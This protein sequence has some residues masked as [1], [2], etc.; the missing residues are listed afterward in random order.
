MSKLLPAL[1]LISFALISA[2]ASHKVAN[3]EELQSKALADAASID[4][5]PEEMISRASQ[6][7]NNAE[8]DLRFYSPLH[9]QKA[10]EQLEEARKLQQSAKPENKT[11]A[12]AAAI[13]AEKLVKQAEENREQVKQQLAPA[14][15]HRDI[16]LELGAADLLPREFNSAMSDLKDLI[17]LVESGQLDAVAKQQPALLEEFARVEASTLKVKWLSRAK[18]KLE[19]AED[20]DAEKFAPKSFEQARLAIERAD[21]YTNTNY[22]DR[23]GVKAK[24]DDAFVLASKAL[25]MTMEVQ[26]VFEKK[27]SEIESYM[28]DVQSWMQHINQEAAVQ[29]LEAFTFYEQS[30]LITSRLS[31]SHSEKSASVSVPIEKD[32]SE[33]KSPENY[34]EPVLF[35]K[36]IEVDNNSRD[37]PMELDTMSQEEE[38]EAQPEEPI[39]RAEP[40]ML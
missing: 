32:I 19:E 21:S 20:A 36:P 5:S 4:L 23:E 33:E 17:I 24:A 2:C 37:E 6:R 40:P 14:L 39:E 1:V 8:Q 3:S 9:M 15:S 31:E 7:L 18:A 10:Q 38:S 13:L 11:G 27:I 16:L 34:Q 22:R 28:H 12:L 26:K 29:D 30:R 25:N 35:V